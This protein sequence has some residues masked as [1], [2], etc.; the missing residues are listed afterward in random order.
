MELFTLL[1]SSLGTREDGQTMASQVV[2]MALIVFAIWGAFS[3]LGH[4]G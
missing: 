1:A 2:A 4:L 3:L